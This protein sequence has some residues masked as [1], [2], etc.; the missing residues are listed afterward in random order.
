[1]KEIPIEERPRERLRNKGVNALGDA[2]LL[3]LLLGTG[4]G[5]ENA[6]ETAHR[7]L[8]EAGGIERMAKWGV[9]SLVEM[10]GI[11]EARA[12]R[13]VAAV[14]IGTRV[15]ERQRSDGR[16]NR[17]GCSADIYA[18][19]RTRLSPLAQ[20]V[21]M[22]VGL[23]NKN[24]VV[25]EVTVAKGSVN[26]CHVSPR[27]VFRPLISEASARMI[28]LHN[29]PSGDP[30]PSPQDV[31]LTKRLVQVGELVGI[32]ML[33]HLVVASSGYVSFRDLG[34]IGSRCAS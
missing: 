34:I 18:T 12:S 5:N 1:M 20:E 24:Q 30:S 33:D 6:L 7:I 32:P 2:E 21:F 14:E 28:A 31:S 9:G 17:F 15:L 29:H 26:E 13:I 3:A 11:G 4:V 22:V 27:E 10:P 8:R 16:K 25:V 23:N 19:Y